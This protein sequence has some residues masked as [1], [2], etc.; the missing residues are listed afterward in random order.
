MG[1]LEWEARDNEWE[2]WNLESETKHQGMGGGRNV[3]WEN[4][5]PGMGNLE[6]GMGSQVT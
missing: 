5:G 3:E 1:N 4:K 6:R 2:A